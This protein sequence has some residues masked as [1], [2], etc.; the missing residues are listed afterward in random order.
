MM[1]EWNDADLIEA[2]LAGDERAWKILVER[3]SRLIYTIPLRLGFSKIVADEIF[4]ETCVTLLE[5][6]D[7][8]RDRT[9]LSSWLMTT[10]RRACIHRWRQKQVV[11]VDLTETTETTKGTPESDLLYLEEQHRVQLAFERL[12]SRCQQLLKALFV[13]DPPCSYEAIAGELD[14]PIGS[15]GPTR[16]RCLKKLRQEFVRLEGQGATESE[17]R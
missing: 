4:Q 11:Q 15:V 8:L 5:K 6:L 3:Y 1:I 12:P 7:T 14:M 9:R 10:T 13:Q 17:N 2:C 16:N